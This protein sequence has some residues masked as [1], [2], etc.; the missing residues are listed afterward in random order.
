MPSALP[1]SEWAVRRAENHILPMPP[2]S[3]S[4]QGTGHWV[5]PRDFPDPPLRL[6]VRPPSPDVSGIVELIRLCREGRIYEVERWIRE[7]RPLQAIDY[8]SG[9]R[10]HRLD[11]P[12]RVAIETRQY[13]LGR[14]LLC[15]GFL[16]D[17][18]PESLLDLVVRSR[19]KD[20]LDLL[21]AWGADPKRVL[22]DTVLDTYDLTL[23][24]RFWEHGVDYTREHVLARYLSRETKNKPAYGWARRHRDDPRVAR[25]LAMALGE[26]L[27]E[28]HEKAALLLI[29]AGADP[30]LKVPDLHSSE[31][32]EKDPEL[33]VSGVEWCVTFGRGRLLPRLK[34]DPQFDDIDRLWA[35]VS[36][37]ASMD[38]LSRIRL[39]TDWSRMLLQNIRRIVGAY[40]N[41]WQAR[42]VIEAASEKHQARIAALDTSGCSYLRREILRAKDTT[43]L[44]WVLR[45]MSR[46]TNCE[47][48][49]YAELTRT[50]SMQ[51]KLVELGVLRRSRS[52][53][54]RPPA[55][56]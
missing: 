7:G 8:R 26:A 15:N 21:L 27:I 39:P 13:D 12:L 48:S 31:D 10:S 49:I 40:G 29:W 28:D 11:S 1:L 44:R 51:S 6:P 20:F 30:H 25:E 53:S 50:A 5:D 22:P 34:P 23:M 41:A 17:S 3:H 14:L 54:S 4:G 33:Q 56:A 43:D 9:A 52:G 55:P 47:P 2:N 36:D 42:S 18:E 45:W 24:E 38:V 16:P 37:P 19:A 46:P 35:S 32:E